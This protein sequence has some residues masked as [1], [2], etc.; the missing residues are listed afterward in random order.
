LD[1]DESKRRVDADPCAEIDRAKAEE[2]DHKNLAE[3]LKQVQDRS[4][5]PVSDIRMWLD[6]ADRAMDIAVPKSEVYAGL[7]ARLAGLL[8]RGFFRMENERGTSRSVYC[9]ATGLPSDSSKRLFHRIFPRINAQ[10]QHAAAFNHA[11]RARLHA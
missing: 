3:Y 5:L 1:L 4:N 8:R 9:S 6:K 10:Q 7:D 2:A 11:Q